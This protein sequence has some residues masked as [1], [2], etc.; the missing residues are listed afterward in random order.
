MIDRGFIKWQPFN[1][2]ITNKE[3]LNNIHNEKNISLPTFFPEKLQILNEKITN[4]YYS[5]SYI[6]LTFYE[7]NLIKTLKTKIIALY[8]SNNTLKLI[9]NQ[10][11][12]FNQIININ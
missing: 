6:N 3:M 10:I 1:S 2:L 5:K 8:P 11:I 12:S 7:N 9:N 4:A